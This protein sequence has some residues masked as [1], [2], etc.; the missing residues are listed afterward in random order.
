MNTLASHYGL[1]EGG[2]VRIQLRRG[3]Q[4][5]AH[6]QLVHVCPHKFQVMQRADGVCGEA[7]L[8][9]RCITVQPIAKAV[10]DQLDRV[11]QGERQRCQQNMQMV[12]HDDICVELVVAQGSVMQER[13]YENISDPRCF[14]RGLAITS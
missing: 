5:G 1:A 7:M 9:N 6:W 14:E 10:L 11:L 3:A 8:P 12:R 13:F 2:R 4:L